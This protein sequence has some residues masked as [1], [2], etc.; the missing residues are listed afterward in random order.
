MAVIKCV[1]L[2]P[3]LRIYAILPLYLRVAY[4]FHDFV[5]FLR[6]FDVDRCDDV[7]FDMTLAH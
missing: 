3:G 6:A 1:P 7:I 4:L 2:V 5:P